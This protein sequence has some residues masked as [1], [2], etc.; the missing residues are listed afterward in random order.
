[1]PDFEQRRERMVE[2]T[3]LRRGLDDPTLLAAFRSVPREEFVGPQYAN[4]AYADAPLAIGS[5][6]T[7][8]QPYIVALMIDAA[9][10]KPGDRVLDVGTGSG[11]AAAVL[12][13]MGADVV[14]IERRPELLATARERLER[15]AYGSVRLVEG[16]GSDGFV[17]AAPYDAIIVGAAA[18][19]VPP[20]F[21]GQLAEGGRIILPI[22]PS[23]GIQQLVSLTRNGEKL[24]REVICDVRFVPLVAG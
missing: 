6:Q 14:S 10:V 11:Y 9:G 18:K 16:D 8:S 17:A 5:G 23:D 7:I 24:I 3:I 12:A 1:M 2:Q 4:D 21:A 19:K 15:L 13:E 20:A 22:G